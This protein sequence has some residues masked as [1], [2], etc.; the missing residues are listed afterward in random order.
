MSGETSENQ[1]FKSP[2]PLGAVGESFDPCHP[3]YDDEAGLTITKS[4]SLELRAIRNGWLKGQRWALDATPGE[5][6]ALSKKR[7]LTGRERLLLAVVTDATS[8]DA[9]IRQIAVRNGLAMDD[10]NME[11]ELRDDPNR[12][13]DPDAAPLLEAPQAAGAQVT[14]IQVNVVVSE[15]EG[16][17]GN[18]AHSKARSV[19]VETNGNGNGHQGNG[20]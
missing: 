18:L 12:G 20:K 3:P 11:Q 4:R 10:K 14:N 8:K 6:A 19:S 9:R 7:E 2:E 16:F 5:I 17:Y 13:R 1:A 15:D